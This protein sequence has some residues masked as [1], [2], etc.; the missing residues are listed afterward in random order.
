MFKIC[1]VINWMKTKFRNFGPKNNWTNNNLKVSIHKL[2][3]WYE[4]LT[5]LFCLELLKDLK[6]II[7]ANQI[8]QDSDNFIV[9]VF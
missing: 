3:Y 7:K 1:Q 5:I 6:L 9:S 4:I 8:Q 2:V